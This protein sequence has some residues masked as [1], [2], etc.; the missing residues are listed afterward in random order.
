MTVYLRNEG[1]SEAR[2]K[3]LYGAMRKAAAALLG[4]NPSRCAHEQIQPT[5]GHGSIQTTERYLG[6]KQ[7]LT[8]RQAT[9]S[10]ASVD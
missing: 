4:V 8:M 3:A 9:G 5:L 6:T 10:I 7:D 2:G 1:Y